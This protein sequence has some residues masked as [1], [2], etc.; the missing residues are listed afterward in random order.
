MPKVQR[1]TGWPRNATQ[2][3]RDLATR[4]PGPAPV[5][6]S[7]PVYTVY[8]NDF[9]PAAS[10]RA[11]RRVPAGAAGVGV[12]A[13]IMLPTARPGLGWLVTMLAM[14]VA[15]GWVVWRRPMAGGRDWWAARWER[16]G[17]AALAVLL[18]AVP[19]V[20][21]ADWLCVLAL[22]AAGV[23]ATLGV[24]GGRRLGEL[25]FALVAVPVAGVRGIAWAGR[26]VR[27][28][29]AD[30]Q[31]TARLAGAV[32]VGVGLV[33]VFG[34]LFATAD[35]GF[36]RLLTGLAPRVDAGSA[37][38][39]VF[40]FCA[41]GLAVVGAGYLVVSRPVW[42]AG[43]VWGRLRRAEWVVPVGLLV[44]LFAAFVGVQVVA[45]FGGSGYVLH[46]PGLTYAQYARGGFWQLSAVTVLT[47]PVIGVV[48][49]FADRD[50][51]RG[52]L[53]G[54]VGAL[55]G[56][57]V[58]IVVS[59]LSRMWS[60]QQAYGFTVL[61]L[62][63]QTCEVWLGVIYLLIL[64]AGVRMRAGWIARSA[65]A[66][67]MVA[68][69]VLAVV[70]PEGYIARHNV[71]RW[72]VTGRLDTRYLEGLS[73]DAVDAIRAL[74]QPERGCVLTV[75]MSRVGADD[76]RS[77]NVSRAAARSELAGQGLVCGR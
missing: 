20:R 48:V 13:A 74:P 8:P 2:R 39:S 4:P 16:L 33:V 73:T 1:A 43:R 25:A 31:R 12:V 9:W 55:A 11:D 52:W 23:A 50:A 44:V 60:Y 22:L 45:M 29:R 30:D 46:T 54:L 62:L 69:L 76:W 41:A 71:E 40:V 34:A 59:A 21:A 68:L 47:L 53:R 6:E 67:G 51:D 28:V 57:T 5:V 35:A 17:W 64:V 14:V 49:A 70:N 38:W 63:V 72:Q 77:V 37:V 36:A 32:L 10:V 75:I 3:R 18:V 65:V 66:L 56:L 58:V 24:T 27:R 42:R 7:T 26:G 19:V 61:R 15:V